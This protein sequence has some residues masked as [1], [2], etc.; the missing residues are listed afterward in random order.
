MNNKHYDDIEKALFY[1]M[2]DAKEYDATIRLTV[3]YYDLIHNTLIDILNYHFGVTI[4]NVNRND[5]D[6]IFLD[7]GAGTGTETISVL[8]TFPKLNSLS[9]DIAPAMK[10]AFDENYD[11]C[12]D[13][14]SEKRFKYIV[15]DI[16]NLDFNKETNSIL[17]EYNQH[18]KVA[19][20]SAYCI[21]HFPLEEKRIIYKKMYDFLDDGGI[22]VNLDLFNYK[23]QKVSEYAHHFDIEYIKREF[24]NPSPEY[25]SSQNMPID[26]RNTLKSKWVGHMNDDNILDTIESQME[27]LREIGFKD[28]E[29][30]FKYIQ[31]GIIIAI[32]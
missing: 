19:A 5:I 27:I 14:S 17:L 28:V 11:K 22:L 9:I 1:A 3:P 26:I 2:S 7:V 10:L 31:Q 20:I 8:K 18:K 21:H 29:C 23:S 24:D 15:D 25:V 32:K 16:F 4:N 6:G 12:F 30:I 13:Q